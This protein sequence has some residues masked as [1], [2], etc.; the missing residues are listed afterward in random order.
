MWFIITWTVRKSRHLPGKGCAVHHERLCMCH[1][2]GSITSTVGECLIFRMCGFLCCLLW[3]L[4]VW[5]QSKG[6]RWEVLLNAWCC[7]SGSLSSSG[8]VNTKAVASFPTSTLLTFVF[9]WSLA[10]DV[11]S[12]LVPIA[13]LLGV[14]PSAVQLTYPVAYCPATSFLQPACSAIWFSAWLRIADPLYGYGCHTTFLHD[15]I[16]AWGW[17]HGWCLWFVNLRAWPWLGNHLIMVWGKLIAINMS[18]SLD[19][20]AIAA[21]LALLI[22]RTS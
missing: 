11:A 22:N 8:A 18:V 1:W 20:S 15:I 2:G 13:W 16:A 3:G 9:K 21:C 6:R 19:W 10:S 14:C 4:L 12:C 17:H 7:T 5:H